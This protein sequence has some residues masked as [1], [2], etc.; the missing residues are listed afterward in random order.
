MMEWPTPR[1]VKKLRGF[2]GLT[3]Y[4]RRF[5]HHY[6]QIAKPLTELLR[7]NAFQW[8]EE[9]KSAFEELKRAMSE[10]PVLKL[11]DFNKEFVVETDASGTGIGVVLLQ[12]GRPVASMSRALKGREVD[13]SVYDKEVLAIVAA[14]AKWQPYLIG[15]HFTIQTDRQSLKYLMKQRISTPSQQRWIAKL[16]GYDYTL[17]YKKG[18][19]NTVADAL[20]RIPHSLSTENGSLHHLSCVDNEVLEHVK[21]S[22]GSDD[23]VKR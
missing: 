3:G 17:T 19:E 13:L 1:I 23:R 10:S 22:W 2:L 21:A 7:K 4:Y 15:R 16:L 6:G 11:P 8:T 18:Q 5:I 20:S 12:E 9:T 14:V